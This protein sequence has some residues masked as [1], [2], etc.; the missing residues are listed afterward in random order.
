MKTN[1]F[2]FITLFTLAS[3]NSGGSSS[4]TATVFELDERLFQGTGRW[5]AYDPGTNIQDDLLFRRETPADGIE[6]ERLHYDS[7]YRS[8][9]ALADGI[10]DL[11]AIAADEI[12]ATE[13]GGVL[14][15]GDLAARYNF[16]D[17]D[18]LEF[19][20]DSDCI[21]FVRN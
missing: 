9:S 3:C 5:T 1:I 15:T 8:G 11:E 10:Y 7:T 18:T 17:D 21:T 14:R 6:R 12:Y 13:F 16:I 20:F 2:A 19:C 4:S